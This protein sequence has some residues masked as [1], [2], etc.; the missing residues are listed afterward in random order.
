[1]DAPERSEAL[2]VHHGWDHPEEKSHK[3]LDCEYTMY[4]EA[5]GNEVQYT[6]G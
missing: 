4:L 5:K 1:M 2:G 3:L 6:V